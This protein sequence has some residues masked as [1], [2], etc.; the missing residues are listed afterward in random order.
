MTRSFGNAVVVS[1]VS[2][3]VGL[4]AMDPA[5]AAGVPM[6]DLTLW[7]KA[8]G[9]SGLTEGQRVTQWADSSGASHDVAAMSIGPT[10]RTNV[11]NG[12]PVVRFA[13]DTAEAMTA[14]L[15][16]F[17][18]PVTV[19]AVARFAQL[20][21]ASSDYDFFVNLGGGYPA[22]S[23]ANVTI[24]RSEGGGDYYYIYSGE[25]YWGPK[26]RGQEWLILT[27]VNDTTAEPHKLWVDGLS[28]TVGQYSYTLSLN[29][30]FMLSGLPTGPSSL[31]HAFDGDV[32]EVLVWK[33]LLSAEELS[34]VGQYLTE[35]W[36]LLTAYS[37]LYA[38]PPTP[39]TTN[40]VL[41]LDAADLDGDGASEGFDESGVDGAFVTQ[42]VDKAT[43]Y[44]AGDGAQNAVQ[45]TA[46]VQPG[47]TPFGL[48]SKPSVTFTAA[49]ATYL[50][51]PTF[52]A[53][54]NPPVHVF[55]VWKGPA[56]GNQI[57]VD[58]LDANHRD[59]LY[60][61]G[62]PATLQ[63]WAPDGGAYGGTI[64]F[65][66]GKVTTALYKTPGSSSSIRVNGVD[67]STGGNSG[68]NSLTGVILG[69]RFE[70]AGSDPWAFQGELQELLVYGGELDAVKRNWVEN[71]LMAK[72]FTPPSIPTNDLTLWV[73]G[74]AMAPLTNGQRVLTWMDS[75]GAG[76]DLK[77][78]WA[79]GPAYVANGLNGLPMAH[80][81]DHYSTPLYA[82]A[83]TITNPV[84]VFAVAYFLKE[85][86]P[87]NDADYLLNIGGGYP[88]AVNGNLSISRYPGGDNR[89]YFYGGGTAPETYYYGPVLIGQKWTIM[90]QMN[91]TTA[92]SHKLWVNGVSQTVD[93]YGGTLTLTGNADRSIVLGGIP[94]WGSPPVVQPFHGCVAEVMVWKRALSE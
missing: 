14:S 61:A 2:L 7:L 19:F 9:L 34:Q 86:Q 77:N 36:G 52:T 12:L 78:S 76:H 41:W 17:T 66:R 43:A 8:D 70:P 42:W 21:Q 40:L 22:A 58:G 54:L 93:Q 90:A 44:V 79:W 48:N 15:G 32:A 24:S 28:Q 56:A 62:D 82:V 57:L 20:H 46:G 25:N 81:D 83:G 89:Y 88:S 16:A 11:L 27:Q 38:N 51:T 50:Q 69:K 45:T 10:Y 59:V 1:A 5:A 39:M 74:D 63:L 49:N 13:N 85:S 33:R 80:F 71:Y 53:E 37:A 65:G 31:V 91:D 26:L 75:S 64:A 6:D 72:W 4:S 94:T 84:T 3:L 35:K 68:G 55:A 67:V 87:Y 92:T 23:G 73:K 60:L 47:Y 30:N 29:G 18:S